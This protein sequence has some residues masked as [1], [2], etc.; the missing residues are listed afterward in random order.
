M[1]KRRIIQAMAGAL[2]LTS[3]VA[4]IFT[5]CESK[6]QKTDATTDDRLAGIDQA[7]TTQS[8][9]T[10]ITI[11]DK[12]EAFTIF[13]SGSA[14]SNITTEAD[15]SISWVA[16]AAG[17]AG[18]GVAFYFNSDKSEIN[19]ANYSSIELEFDYSPVAGKWSAKAQKPGF[20]MRILPWD[21][22]GLFGGFEDLEYFDS[23]EESGTLKKTI[24]IPDTFANKIKASSDFD[25]VLGFAL[26]FNDY[27]RGNADGDQLAV[28]LKSVKLNA[29]SNA[30]A[31]NAFD[32][33]LTAAQRG[34]VVEINYPTRDYTVAENALKDSDKYS[35]HAWVYLPAGYDAND[36]ATKYPVFILLHGFGQNEN[37]W[38]LTNQGRGGKIK[39]YM[40]R[41]MANGEVEKFILV[42]ATGVAD[43]S[44]GPNGTGG[45]FNGYNVFGGE[46]R[47]DLLPYLRQNFNIKDGR[48]NVAIAGLSMGGGQTFTIGIG[49]CLD[50]ISN[51]AGFS[52][53]L[54]ST[55]QEFISK[56]DGNKAFDGLKIHNLYMICG[57]AD[58][59]V[60]GSFPGYVEAMKNW[61]TRVEN[62]SSYVY[63]GGTHD[64]PVWYRG[65]NDFIHMVFK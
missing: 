44:W 25:S 45:S 64:F 3:L 37:T 29:K 1:K 40:D 34:T 20:C 10:G 30:P 63:P 49:E 24:L 14:A 19:I 8:G 12:T 56:V 26:K 15:G 4:G 48:D 28:T 55:S 51:F 59:L 13:A 43:K 47:N 58:Y 42:C 52:G 5:S 38:G 39:G 57:D 31:D 65:F 21:S 22:T 54:F 6:K 46:L 33:G 7:G 18:G 11:R 2:V 53:A 61:T 50:L 17:G 35:K 16:T 23:T 60:Y 62:F 41:G 27:N 36:K 32:D 9:I